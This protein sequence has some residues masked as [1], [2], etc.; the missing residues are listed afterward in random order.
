M[1]NLID[2]FQKYKMSKSCGVSISEGLDYLVSLKDSAE[3]EHAFFWLSKEMIIHR[4]PRQQLK[5]HDTL[6]LVVVYH[7]YRT[8]RGFSSFLLEKWVSSR[9]KRQQRTFLSVQDWR[10]HPKVIKS[11][12]QLLYMTWPMI[13]LMQRISLL[14]V[15]QGRMSSLRHDIA[16]DVQMESSV[17]VADNG[18][19]IFG[20]Q[21][22]DGT[23]DM[24]VEATDASVDENG[25]DSAP[26]A[27]TDLQPETT[28][29]G[30][31]TPTKQE[32]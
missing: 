24:T 7:C 17:G 29:Q 12:N 26:H 14:T 23:N 30:R 25:K 10:R 19:D 6:I 28:K 16:D 32:G 5:I 3:I 22:F 20:T 21:S 31:K 15:E 9:Q 13:L 18:V 8:I 11:M 1:N 27:K 2:L 4:M